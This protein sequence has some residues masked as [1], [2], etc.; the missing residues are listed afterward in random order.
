[1]KKIVD[2]SPLKIVVVGH[3]D[4]GKSSII[5]RLFY[6]TGGLPEGKFEEIQTPNRSFLKGKI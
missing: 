6:E 4:H 5:G 2:E 3:V 1:M